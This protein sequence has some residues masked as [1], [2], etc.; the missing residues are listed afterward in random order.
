MTLPPGA[1]CLL[2]G[3]FT[4]MAGLKLPWHLRRLNKQVKG[5]FRFL[6]FLL[7]LKLGRGFYS[8]DHFGRAPD[9]RTDSFKSKDYAGGG[10]V[11]ACGRY[12][13]SKYGSRASRQPIDYLE[14]DTV[15]DCVD[16]MGAF[17][18]R[19]LV[20]LGIDNSSFQGSL[21]KGRS[22][23][24]RL[25]NLV[26]EL[27]AKQVKGQFIIESFWLSSEDNLLA[28]HLSRDRE[29]A[30]L[31]D[32]YLTGFWGEDVVPLKMERAHLTRVLP[33]RRGEL[34]R[35]DFGLQPLL[36]PPPKYLFGVEAIEA[37]RH[38]GLRGVS[39]RGA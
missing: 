17:W 38:L 28:D 29:A 36:P 7:G 18:H 3:I 35:R 26:R 24:P 5:D 30:F 33:E 31:R 9:V 39:R 12:S 22:K 11:S 10:W 6:R 4:L 23:A 2:V 19:C 21:S 1:A 16:N 14:G 15:V 37:T 34:A 25:N 8:L 32:A 27:F 20:P 13:L